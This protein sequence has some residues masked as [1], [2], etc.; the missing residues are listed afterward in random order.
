MVK[1]KNIHKFTRQIFVVNF[2]P[3]R[4]GHE[5][6]NPPARMIVN[7]YVVLRWKCRESQEQN[8]QTDNNVAS[9]YRPRQPTLDL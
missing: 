7:T 6:S 9:S 8:Y 4:V 2:Y 1:Q 3:Q 5:P